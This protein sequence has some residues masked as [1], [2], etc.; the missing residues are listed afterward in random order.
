MPV[1]YPSMVCNLRLRFDEAFNVL[2]V[3]TPVSVDDLSGGDIGLATL[4]AA[5]FGPTA[6]GQADIRPLI[7]RRGAD[8]LSQISARIPKSGS[9]E[10]N[11]FRHAGTFQLTFD[12]QDLPIDPRLLRSAAV[13]IHLGAVPAADFGRGMTSFNAS[14]ARASILHTLDA[15]GMPRVDTLLL[16]GTVDS[17]VVEHSGD[18]STVHIEGRDLRGLLLDSPANPKLFKNLDLSQPI[19]GGPKGVVEQI[20]SRHPFGKDFQVEI[21][22][23]DFDGGSVPSPASRDGVTRVRLNADGNGSGSAKPPGGTDQFNYWDLITR[24]CFLVGALPY[25]IGYKLRIRPARSI[26]DLTKKAGFDPRV[27]TPFAGGKTRNATV[28]NP[29][30]QERLNIRRLVYG[31][32]I[33]TLRFERKYT[34]VKA[35]VIECI[36]LNTS[37]AQR[38]KQKLIT[39]RWPDKLPT[40]QGAGFASPGAS[41]DKAKVTSVSTSGQLSESELLRIPVPGISDQKRLLQIAKDLFEEIGRGEMGGNCETKNLASFGGDNTD[42]D[43]LHLFPGDP[44]EF[45]ADVRSLGS[46]SPVVSELTNQMRRS[47]EE[48]VAEI[49]KKIPDENL[50]RV[51]VATARGSIVELQRLFRVYNVHYTWGNNGIAIAFDFQN[52]IEARSGVTPQL[53]P[54]TQAPILTPVGGF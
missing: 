20:L 47:F 25:F 22:P 7:T 6:P 8:N 42:P 13:E 2:N 9:V 54:N 50:A 4:Q 33:S 38:G 1:F 41:V 26:Y 49:K 24:Y 29:P 39:A 52:Y 43:L 32:D 3:P 28:G 27:P 14:G 17:W 10:L 44:I 16:A 36:S 21:H 11:G 31:R 45:Q 53:G 34:G 19:A 40:G 51:I 12:F 15:G 46:K 35:R 37:S 5:E 18:S 23:Q 30:H 48:Q